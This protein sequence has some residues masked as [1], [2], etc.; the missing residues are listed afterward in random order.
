M[1]LRKSAL[2]AMI[3]TSVVLLAALVFIL[4]GAGPRFDFGAPAGILP[5]AVVGVPACVLSFSSVWRDIILDRP[6]AVPHAA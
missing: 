4:L 1:H 2:N 6:C 3:L 5:F